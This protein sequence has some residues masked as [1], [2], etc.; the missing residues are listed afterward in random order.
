MKFAHWSKTLLFALACFGV[1]ASFAQTAG[2]KQGELVHLL[3]YVARP[4]CQFNRNGKW[5]AGEAARAHLQKKFDYLEQRKQVP[6]AEAFI[7]RAAT[8]SS[9]SGE[10]YQVRC[11]SSAPV[12]AGAW[13]S[14]E[15][16]R[17][18]ASRAPAALR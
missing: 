7:E 6:T 8:S 14:D 15:L 4:D 12:P 13:L 5:Y 18:R 2:R 17:Y 10:P 11:G 9:I 16:K 3:E 1:G